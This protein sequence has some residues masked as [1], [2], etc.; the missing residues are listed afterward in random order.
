MSKAI[1]QFEHQEGK[2]FYVGK[3]GEVSYLIPKENKYY[4]CFLIDTE[5]GELSPI[6]SASDLDYYIKE[7]KCQ[8]IDGDA[9]INKIEYDKE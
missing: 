8:V 2:K 5:T 9:S 4:H 1:I 7:E 6:T 3:G